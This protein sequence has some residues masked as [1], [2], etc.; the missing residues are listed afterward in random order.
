MT[1]YIRAEV[2]KH[3]MVMQSSLTTN[4]NY[5]QEAVDLARKISLL[6]RERHAKWLVSL[7]YLLDQSDVD[8]VLSRQ[9]EFCDS[10]ILHEKE[11]ITDNQRLLL[12]CES[13]RV[14]ERRQAIEERQKIHS[15][16][17]DDVA[18]YAQEQIFEKLASSPINKIFNRFPDFSHFMSIAYSPSL[19]Y[20]KLSVLTTNDTQLKS[21]VIE[22]A[23]NPKFCERIGKSPRNLQDPKVAIGTLGIENSA[24]LFPILMARR[25]LRWQDKP[26]KNIAPKLWQYLILTAN[27]TRLRLE[28]GNVK[29]PEQGVLLGVLRTT[30]HFAVI[31]HFT[32]MYEDSLVDKM[33]YY[34]ENNMRE[35]YYACA[36]VTPNLSIIPKLI[37]SLEKTI[38]QKLID[39]LEWTPFNIHMKSALQEDLDEVPILE[40]SEAGVALAQ[41]QA[42]AIYDGLERSNVF[43][44]KH[45]PF[46][47][48]NVQMSAES[49][50]QIRKKH[51]GKVELSS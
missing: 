45:K 15:F 14:K 27:V 36:D 9:G 1:Y 11:R 22:L 19:N 39:S 21:E 3:S 8:G 25:L 6:T 4:K 13:S 26:T 16:V 2:F 10:V 28:Q 48:A 50:Q 17:V 42:Y 18:A 7:K 29:N 46:W 20:T 38:T 12:E 24:L 44:E 40:R 35:E 47:F 31:N 23:N 51:P 32:Q 34:R 41:A 30:S 5:N 43:V 33:R 49:I 37:T